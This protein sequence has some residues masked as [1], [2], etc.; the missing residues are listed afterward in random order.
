MN[1]PAPQNSN[2]SR[3]AATCCW[4]IGLAAIA[5]ALLSLATASTSREAG[6]QAGGC[7][8]EFTIDFAGL[9]AGTI[10]GEQYAGFGVHISGIA[11]ASPSGED[12]PDAL[13]VFDTN[14]PP[15]HD[16]DLAVD[17]GNIAIF[18]N[19]LTDVDPADGLVDDPDENNFGGTATFAFD[20]E[21]SIGSVQ[22]VDKDH[23]NPNF[24]VAYNAAGGV[25]VSVPV[26]VGANASVQQIDINADGVRRLVFVYHESGGFTGIEVTCPQPTPSP[27]STSTVQ[28]PGPTATPT[29]A[30]TATPTAPA[31]PTPTQP[32]TPSPTPTVQ[33]ATASPSPSPTVLAD[34]SVLQTPAAG[35]LP[36]GGGSPSGGTAAF[37]WAT[38]LLGA[39][40]V[41]GGSFAW[42]RS[43]RR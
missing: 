9:P 28:T 37:S 13:I 8:A 34:T 30:A 7:P 32:P 33:P 36:A 12:F 14:A 35:G 11:N 15:T 21:V 10:I 41:A 26:P 42:V 31:T 43:G 23:S 3:L 17:I 4:S 24:V 18:A 22:W 39:M 20:Q 19:N 29:V 25:I 40:L 5:I 27:T 1:Q 38:A 6:A 2:R 16:P